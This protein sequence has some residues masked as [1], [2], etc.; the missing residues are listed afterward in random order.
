[1]NDKSDSNFCNLKKTL[2]AFL[3]KHPD[4]KTENKI[5]IAVSGGP[6]SMALA[7]CLIENFDK[8]ITIISVDHQLRVESNDEIEK[9]EKWAAQF[10][11][12]RI[13]FKR[14]NWQ[15]LKP[16]KAIMENA[17]SARY[18]LMTD[19]CAV[20]NIKTL[21]IGH[22]QDD[23]AETFLMRLSKGSGLDGLSCMKELTQFDRVLLARPFLKHLKSDLIDYCHTHQIPF[24]IDPSNKNNKFMR[25]RLRKIM[26][27]LAGEGLTPK[28]LFLTAK[29][30]NRAREALEILTNNAL[31]HLLLESDQNV[32]TLDFQ[33]FKTYPEEIGLRVLKHCLEEFRGNA[34]YNVR[35][36]RLEDLFDAL[37]LKPE[38]F[39]ARTLG[40]C[41]IS[42]LNK[43]I[44][45]IEKEA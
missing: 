20:E 21:F 2:C 42:L 24:L 10:D 23:Q 9:I 34:Q 18:D 45:R 8:H 15:G 33:A 4:I 16:D 7:H 40:G 22:H 26:D 19:F 12:T 14:L 35:M 36:E 44:L 39:T 31:H 43:G 13:F 30:L 5:A 11:S 6:D 29:R 25:P 1:M 17:R 41:K 27:G 38:I 32:I 3:E 28:R 37:W